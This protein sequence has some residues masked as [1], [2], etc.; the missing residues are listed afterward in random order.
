MNY[1]TVGRHGTAAPVERRKYALA[2]TRVPYEPQFKHEIFFKKIIENGLFSMVVEDDNE[3]YQ[4][5]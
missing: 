3:R 2:S 4:P 1:S 5:L